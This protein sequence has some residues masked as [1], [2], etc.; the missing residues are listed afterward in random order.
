MLSSHEA[1]AEAVSHDSTFDI[2]ML[3]WSQLVMRSERFALINQEFPESRFK[4]IVLA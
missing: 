1:S 2:N 3:N 4:F